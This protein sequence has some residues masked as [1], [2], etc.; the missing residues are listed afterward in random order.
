MELQELRL[1]LNN[2]GNKSKEKIAIFVKICKKYIKKIR[3]LLNLIT[4]LDA[5]VKMSEGKE[6]LINEMYTTNEKF[7]NTVYNP[8]LIDTLIEGTFDNTKKSFLE[9]SEDE[10]FF[11]SQVSLVDIVQNLENQV[12]SLQVQNENL[13]KRRFV[14]VYS[15]SN[16]ETSGLRE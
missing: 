16:L 12:K 11:S 8:K 2:K 6:L 7:Y 3:N 1:V 14:D 10:S 4:K 5:N 13:R 15:L 9:E